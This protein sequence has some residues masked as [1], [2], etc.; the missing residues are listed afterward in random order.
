MIKEG[1]GGR[2]NCRAQSYTFLGRLEAEACD[3]VTTEKL[4]AAHAVEYFIAYKVMMGPICGSLTGVST[5]EVD[6]MMNVDNLTFSGTLNATSN[7]TPANMPRDGSSTTI[8]D[9]VPFKDDNGYNRRHFKSTTNNALHIIGCAP[10]Q[11]CSTQ[12][13]PLALVTFSKFSRKTSNRIFSIGPILI[14]RWKRHGL[15]R[16]VG[17]KR[18]AEEKREGRI[19]ATGL[20]GEAVVVRWWLEKHLGVTPHI[21]KERFQIS[22]VTGGTHGHHS[23]TVDILSVRPV[24]PWFVTENFPRTQSENLAKSRLT[25]RPT[26][27][28]SDHGPWIETSLT[29]PLTQTTVDQHG[30]SIDPWSVGLTVDED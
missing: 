29:Q 7:S 1:H 15:S 11:E 12:G 19:G 24:G 10:Y 20:G 30:P 16:L 17:K 28:R 23:R 14:H 25:D 18:E 13:F 21:Q 9:D 4:L 5:L 26:V 22:G 8:S 27:R 6:A 3:V 2:G